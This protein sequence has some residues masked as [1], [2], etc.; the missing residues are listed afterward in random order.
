MKL[1]V[2][3]LS[4]KIFVFDPKFNKENMANINEKGDVKIDKII[5]NLR[6]MVGI[7]QK[8][9]PKFRFIQFKK[10]IIIDFDES[11]I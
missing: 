11:G 10:S 9:I 1:N 5:Q 7:N 3:E 2:E 4:T 6:C 8:Y